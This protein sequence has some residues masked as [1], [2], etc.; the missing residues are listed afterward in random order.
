[1]FFSALFWANFPSLPHF[2][3]SSAVFYVFPN[4][5]LTRA[6]AGVQALLSLVS[7]ASKITVFVTQ[8][9]SVLCLCTV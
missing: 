3:F 1:M 6:G 7:M 9:W 2:F 5:A 8:G 4:A